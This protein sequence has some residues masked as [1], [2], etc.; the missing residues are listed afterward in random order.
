MVVIYDRFVFF[1]VERKVFYTAVIFLSKYLSSEKLRECVFVGHFC[2]SSACANACLYACLDVSEGGAYKRN[3]EAHGARETR[4]ISGEINIE[5]EKDD[6]F[7][8]SSKD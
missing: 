6:L 2:V 8:S 7:L 1:S 5:K 4:M 3:V